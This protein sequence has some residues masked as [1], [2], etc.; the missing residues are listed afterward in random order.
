MIEVAANGFL[1]VFTVV[2]VLLC[3]AA[4]EYV[5]ECKR[6]NDIEAL[7]LRIENQSY[8]SNLKTPEGI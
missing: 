5:A 8:F 2:G 4:F 6:A 1:F 7:R 3:R